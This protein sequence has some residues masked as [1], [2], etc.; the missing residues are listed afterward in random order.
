[1]TPE[2]FREA[3]HDLI[4]WIAD[5]RAGIGDGPVLAA[6]EP[7]QVASSFAPSP[8]SE[9]VT[10]TSVLDELND[11]IVPGITQVQHPMHY[12][13][14]PSNASLSS[15][16][17]DMASSGLGSLGISWESS[18]ALTEVEQVV[19]DWM[20]QLCGLSERW[21]GT[22]HDTASTACF[23]A[24][25]SA[26]ERA[27]DHAQVSG[28]L[29]DPDRPLTVYCTAQAH[30][31]VRKA[32]L[33]AG[34][35][36]DNL[37]VVDVDPQTY[38]MKSDDLAAMIESDLAAGAKPAC[39]VATVG[40]TGTTAIDPL[41]A[42]AAIARQHDCWLHVD[43]AMAG[44]AMLLPEQRH[45]FDGIEE[46]DSLCWNPHKWMGT[47]LDT[48]LYYV[49]DPEHL[50]RVMSTNPSYLQSAADGKVVQYRDWGIPLGRRFRSLKLLFHLRLDGIESI[51]A[52]LRRDL[53]NAQW[54]AAEIEANPEWDLV[55]PVPFQTVCTIHRPLG[56]DGM[57]L[58]G[59]ELD[60]HNRAWVERL[61]RTGN[62]YLTTTVV[63]GRWIVRV[64]IGVEST[65]R[66]HV[67][68]LWALM[69]TTADETALSV[70]PE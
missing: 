23:V 9:S 62:A 48:S 63:E 37:R 6:V 55:A 15:V 21:S 26:R 70:R 57:P 11:V 39:I 46:A 53:D 58:N 1:M 8:P 40:T 25:L 68:A 50:I 56:A 16:L 28:G 38:A 54:L 29:R 14:F 41:A 2:Q 32:A 45:L 30:S 10:M 17:G 59:E 12:G 52:R 19:C 13:W 27:S 66:E 67:E 49:A 5:Y 20:R 22:I 35:G 47:I 24:L 34:Y 33:L 42:V 18:P 31:S 69:Q 61:N 65:E 60:T 43:A 3:G 64:S 7:G 51:R 44:S 4:D 36:A